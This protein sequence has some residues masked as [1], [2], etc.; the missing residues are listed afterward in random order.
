MKKRSDKKKEI[1]QAE[2]KAE[3]RVEQK[4]SET[5]VSANCLNCGTKLLGDFCYNCG[6]KSDVELFTFKTLLT[7]LYQSFRKFDAELRNTFIA[8]LKNPGEF[9]RGYLAGKRKPYTDPVKF[10]F[11]SFVFQVTVFGFIRYVFQNPTIDEA[12]AKVATIV[13]LM[14]LSSVL[15][16]AIAFTIVFRRTGYNLAENTVCLLFLTSEARIL[17]VFVQ[18]IALPLYVYFSINGD[19]L[20]L[21]SLAIFF[22]YMIYFS[23]QF[24]R[25]NFAKVIF[26]NLLVIILFG[27]L[28]LPIFMMEIFA[29][30]FAQF[31]SSPK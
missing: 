31:F 3:E 12:A 9:C 20:D 4:I 7:Y 13:Q 11:L 18:I 17:S 28:Y 2:K 24:Y 6:Q 15:F 14:I 19:L 22:V 10:F 1:T 21:I 29:A 27:I 16:W 25:E 5:S 23:R 30:V 8:L 26:K